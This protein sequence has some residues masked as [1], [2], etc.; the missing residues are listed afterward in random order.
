MP[1]DDWY[2]ADV[3]PVD[4]SKKENAFDSGGDQEENAVGN[5]RDQYEGEEG[6]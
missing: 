6:Y 2:Q 5:G 1:R 4:N 3:D